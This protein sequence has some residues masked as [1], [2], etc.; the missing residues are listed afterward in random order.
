MDIENEWMDKAI[1]IW[2]QLFW[3]LWYV[4]FRYFSNVMS[5]LL[6]SFLENVFLTLRYV[7][8]KYT[9]LNCIPFSRQDA[10]FPHSSVWSSISLYYYSV[11]PCVSHTALSRIV[12]FSSSNDLSCHLL[13][14]YFLVTS[15][16]RCVRRHWD[17]FVSNPST[18]LSSS[19]FHLAQCACSSFDDFDHEQHKFSS[20]D[21]SSIYV[22]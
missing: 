5:Y 14:L 18:V 22:S 1:V 17:T 16:C 21:S 9:T 6:L 7:T 19:W 13:L 2:S 20:S 4:C 3:L 8:F 11:D 12:S 10:I 15:S